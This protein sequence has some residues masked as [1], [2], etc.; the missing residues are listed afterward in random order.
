MSWDHFKRIVLFAVWVSSLLALLACDTDQA[1]PADGCAPDSALLDLAKFDAADAGVTDLTPPDAALPDTASPPPTPYEMVKTLSALAMTG[2]KSGTPGG[3]AAAQYVA[4]RFSACGIKPFGEKPGSYLQTFKVTP[5]VHTGKMEIK[6]TPDSSSASPFSLTYRQEWRCGRTS[7]ASNLTA[8]LAFVGYSLADPGHDSYKGFDAT[9]K[10]VI[11]LR[12]CPKQGMKGC[13]DVSKV[14]LAA[15][16]KAKGFILIADDDRSVDM[17]G[18]SQGQVMLPVPT[19]VMKQAPAEK[20]LPSGNTL[21]ALK[22]TLQIKPQAFDC[23]KKMTV[24]MNRA[25]YKNVDAYNVLGIIES[26]SPQPEGYVI[27]GAHYDHLGFDVPPS[28]YFPGALDNASGTAV[29]IDAACR[30]AK[31]GKAPPRRHLVFAAWGAEEDGLIG[32]RH[33]VKSNV[34]KPSTIKTYINLDM[35]GGKGT[36]PLHVDVTSSWL[37]SLTPL[38]TAQ[39]QGSAVTSTLGTIKTGSSDHASFMSVGVPAVYLYGPFPPDL[40]YHVTGD[41]ISQM[42]AQT[43][44]ELGKLL[45]SMMWKMGEAVSIFTD[46]GTL[47]DAGLPPASNP[48]P[49]AKL[50]SVPAPDPRPWYQRPPEQPPN[51]EL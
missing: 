43:L 34:L 13:D 12:G 36:A 21:K 17:W 24:V 22:A 7:P 4:A 16:K 46:A 37:P 14:K 8:P 3:T 26:S 44:D 39:L 9:G 19:V 11:A 45:A 49:G 23:A 31:T 33:Y 47:S 41:T 48:L 2:R 40:K 30:L 38:L 15:Q 25:V 51:A 32:S 1:L 50:P 5:I 10:I 27:T 18:G 20:L 29:V 42:S 6:V 35:V 28:S